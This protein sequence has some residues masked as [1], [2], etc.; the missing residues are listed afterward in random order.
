MNQRNFDLI[1]KRLCLQ[2]SRCDSIL[3][4]FFEHNQKLNESRH[5]CDSA[6]C[7]YIITFRSDDMNVC[8]L[9]EHF[10]TSTFIV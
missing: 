6:I 9:S 5:K 7:K 2:L 3:L 4:T 8:N 10:E 1:M